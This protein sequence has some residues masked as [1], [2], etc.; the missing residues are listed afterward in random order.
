LYCAVNS[1]GQTIDFLLCE[2]R[3]ESAA[4]A[5]F[6]QAIAHQ[7]WPETVTLDGSRANQATLNNQ[8]FSLELIG[9][10]LGDSR[11]PKQVWVELWIDFL[12]WSRTF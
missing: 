3:D 7:D 6:S 11:W 9:L 5:F 10:H 2:R 8:N 4:R 1:E 12:H